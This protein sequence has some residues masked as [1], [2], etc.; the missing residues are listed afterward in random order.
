MY[1]IIYLLAV[2]KKKENIGM[3]HVIFSSFFIYGAA[4]ATFVVAD[5]AGIVQF[6]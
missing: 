2:K 5:G 1:E 4:A 3:I 6:F